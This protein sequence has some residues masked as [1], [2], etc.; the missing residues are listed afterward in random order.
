EM[1]EIT[2]GDTVAV[3]GCGPVGQFAIA[4]ALLLGA[5]RV[6]AVDHEQDRL[7]LAR[8]QGAET[9][10]FD[11][12]DPVA[13]LLRLTGGIG[14]DRAIDAVGVDAEPSTQL[15]DPKELGRFRAEVADSAPQT[16][17]DGDHWHPGNAPSQALYWAGQS[18]ATARSRS[19][20]GLPTPQSRCL[21]SGLAA[22]GTLT[23]TMARRHQRR[24]IPRL[25]ALVASGRI[26]PTDVLTRVGPLQDSTAAF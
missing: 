4:S 13:T 17:P 21:P 7:E 5:S 26:D 18:L 8:R 12:E 1:A 19:I 22:S 10:H 14:V 15:D 23:V 24:Y 9:I 11:E 2:P 25:I 6:F 16:N 20:T 3:F